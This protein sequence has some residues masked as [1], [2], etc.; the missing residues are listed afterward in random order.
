MSAVEPDVL[1][2]T[3]VGAHYGRGD[4]AVLCVACRRFVL[5]GEDV[6]PAAPPLDALVQHK[7]CP[8]RPPLQCPSC[9]SPRQYGTAVGKYRCLSGAC[10]HSYTERELAEDRCLLLERIKALEAENVALRAERAA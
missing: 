1:T 10:G 4:S 5:R 9:S 7:D 3:E 8:R 6:V 2:W